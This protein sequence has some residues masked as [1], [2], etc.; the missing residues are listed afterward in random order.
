MDRIIDVKNIEKYHKSL[1]EVP[2][3]K[4]IKNAVM[5][6]GINNIAKNNKVIAKKLSRNFSIEIKTSEVSNQ[7]Q[8]GRCW[9][10]AT[11]NTLRHDFE[12]K[13]N[14]KSFEFSQNYLS[15]YDRFEKANAFY[16]FVIE[17]AKEPFDSRIVTWLFKNC[18]VDGG[19]W[20]NSAALI[21]KYGAVPKYAME[22][23]HASNH[24]KEFTQILGL[25][26]RKDGMNLR[27]MVEEGVDKEN[28]D[29]RVKMMLDE[30]YRMCAYAFGEPVKKFDLEFRNEDDEYI[31]D[32]K[33]TPQEF[34]KK[35]IGRDLDDYVVVINSP[36]KELNK[37]YYIP[38][39]RNV[40]GGQD[41]TFLNVELDRFK[42]LL[43]KQVSDKEVTWFGADVLQGMSRDEGLLESKLFNYKD[44][45]NVDFKMSKAD[46]LKYY[47][48]VTAHAMTITGVNLVEGKPNRWKVENTWG[49][50][51]GDKGFFVMSDRWL[52][53][54]V[55][56]IVINKK[57][58]SEDELKMLE[59]EKVELAPWDS[60][61]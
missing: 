32:L 31:Q 58:L 25:K 61:A 50:K 57:Y 60:M 51:V 44:L 55:Y 8:S 13:H 2:N 43:L 36:E 46:R 24:T 23:T 38:F 45:F 30:V 10:F 47:E 7:K 56:H 17:T 1:K 42:E 39:E 28:L 49:D 40:M 53:D 22:E 9:L 11:L 33:I 41:V 54:Y 19:Q 21:K 18:D 15:F 16:N 48:A 59:K 14:V 27:K 37:M 29:K 12:V 3:S 52:E 26:L 6:N 20:D 5:N 35:Y 34:Y 4:I